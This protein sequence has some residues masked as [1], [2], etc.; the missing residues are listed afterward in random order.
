LT[1]KRCQALSL[2]KVKMC[3][4]NLERRDSRSDLIG[5]VDYVR[6]DVRGK[7]KAE[8]RQLVRLVGRSGAKKI[9]DKVETPEALEELLELGFDCFQGYYFARPAIKVQRR[10][11]PQQGVLVKLLVELKKETAI[12]ELVD[13]FKIQVGMGATLLR[14]VNKG[15]HDGGMAIESVYQALVMM[16]RRELERWVTLLLFASG[17]R[18]G[19]GKFVIGIGGAA[20]QGHRVDGHAARA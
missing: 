17:E 1:L 11:D 15:K 2:S 20:R 14:L 5:L 16:G 9:A 8:I 3:L 7:K 6:I 10:V 4:D 18:K 13:L 12:E 19:G